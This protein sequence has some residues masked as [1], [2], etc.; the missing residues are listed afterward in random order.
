MAWVNKTLAE[1]AKHIGARL[2]G[3][4]DCVISGVGTLKLAKSG[5]L[6]FLDNTNYR[7]YLR[8]TQASVVIL[9][10]ADLSE[11]QTNALVVDE[12]YF[13]YA[14]LA[15]LFTKP[16]KLT[17]GIHPS[18]VLGQDCQIDDSVS[19][20]AKVV[21]EDDVKIA[22]NSVIGPGCV[23]G[24]GSV[25]GVSC[26][27]E[28]NATIY[29]NVC[30]GNRVVIYSGAVIGSDGFGMAQ[31]DKIWHKVPQLGS[32][33]IG[34]DVE[35][36]ANTTIDRGTINNTIIE[37]GVKLDNQIQIAHNVCI[38]EHTVIA[39]CTGIA[40]SAKVGRHCSVGGG[41][42]I[43]GHIE[44]ADYTV[45]AGTATVSK[46]ITR[47]GIYSSG[48]GLMPHDQ[49]VKNIARFR[50]LDKT[51]REIKQNHYK[52]GSQVLRPQPAFRVERE[53]V[54]TDQAL[55]IQEVIKRL[56]QRPPF[57]LIDR[58]VEFEPGK[59]LLGIKNV[60]INEAY[61]Q[62]HFP[63]R[64]VMPGVL[65]LECLAQAGTV[66]MFCSTGEDPQNSEPYYFAGIDNARFK[67]MVEPGDQL[68]LKAEFTKHRL[69]VWKIRGEASVGG[70]V[71]CIADILSA[72]PQQEKKS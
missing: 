60:T 66:L 21:I 56:P 51:I 7:R 8:D 63:G 50:R 47:P 54:V 12:P 45:L 59:R 72:K 28:A 55:N 42:S 15:Q 22:A 70:E 43:N 39:A 23:I 1:L 67:R 71:V 19:I 20:G 46:S 30:I 62:G 35:I 4:P 16:R 17:A 69:N 31:K 6:T 37:R 26:V 25:L 36:G 34:D 40:G 64:P 57:L 61:F 38:G 41:A 33:I 5:D 3:D 9:T 68:L 27:I 24:A 14:Q 18:A 11:C 53:A 44:I 29:H 13:A 49:T 10:A 48:T 52:V 65:I 58:V 32:V 2:E